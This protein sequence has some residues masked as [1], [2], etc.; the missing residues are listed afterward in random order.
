[1]LEDTIHL[2]ESKLLL[3]A[4][5]EKPEGFDEYH[6]SE[7]AKILKEVYN[8]EGLEAF[9]TYTRAIPEEY[10]GEVLLELP[11]NIKDEA[12]NE[13]SVSKLV[14]IVDE[15]DSDDAV[16]LMQDIEDI[17]SD[18]EREVLSNLDKE[19]IEDIELLKKYEEDEAGALMQ[20]ELFSANLDEMI[21]EAV[22]R[23]VSYTHLTLPT[24]CSV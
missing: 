24:I 20:T 12:L 7:I 19:D 14:D 17:D 3:E 13:L 2:K 4:L 11:E 16:D 9:L 22:E 5:L 6:A 10:L 15:L 1:M 18:K 23:P 8:Q 21:G